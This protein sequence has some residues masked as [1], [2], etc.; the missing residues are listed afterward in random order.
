VVIV[1]S[2]DVRGGRLG[3]GSEQSVAARARELVAEGAV[4]LHLV[5][6]DGAETGM[7]LNL[8]LLAEVARDVGVPCRLAGGVSRIDDARRAIDRGFAGVLFSSA[9]F[10]D[11]EL[12]R[13]IASF[14]DRAIVE[15]EARAG[16]LAPRGGETRLVTVATG[17]GALASARAAQLAGV[18][19]L[20][21]IDLT[22]EAQLAGPPLALVDTVRAVVGQRVALHAGGGVRDLDDVRAL[23]TR[24]VASVVIGRALAE[25]RFTI[26]A[27][28]EVA[29]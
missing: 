9:V 3:D 1:P 14:G 4:E 7:F 6:L 20:Y 15:I 11:D 8:E 18:R 27:A 21:L 19:A 28:R 23:A 17:R 5:D 16:F 13:D 2:V 25:K 10:G 24:G 12:L 22:S 26:R 29:A